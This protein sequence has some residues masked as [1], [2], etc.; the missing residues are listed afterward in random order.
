MTFQM[1]EIWKGESSSGLKVWKKDYDRVIALAKGAYNSTS[2]QEIQ[3]ESLFFLARV[4]HVRGMMDDAGK[5][6]DR[7]CK[8]NPNLTPA[9]FGL[10]QVLIYQEQYDQAAAHL[11][12]VLGTSSTATDALATLT[13]GGQN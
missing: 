12:L 2:V 4:Y 7:S 6:Y 5:V 13:T 3:A 8:L 11:Q 10:A 1:K 9:R